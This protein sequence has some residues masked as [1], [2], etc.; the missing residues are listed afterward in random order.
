MNYKDVKSIY[1]LAKKYGIAKPQTSK[2]YKDL[3]K[4]ALS[5]LPPKWKIIWIPKK[6]SY[7]FRL[8]IAL[9]DFKTIVIPFMKDK[10][11]EVEIL[12]HEIYHSRQYTL[13][14]KEILFDNRFWDELEADLYSLRNL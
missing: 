5:L 12:F 4:F 3:T 1:D 9:H 8:P 6:I 10:E 13:G 2:I 11:Q 14:G 7:S